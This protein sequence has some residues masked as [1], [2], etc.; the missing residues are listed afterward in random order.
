M[1]GHHALQ[2]LSFIF[3]AVVDSTVKDQ[4]VIVAMNA[5]RVVQYCGACTLPFE[6]SAFFLHHQQ[7]HV[8]ADHSHA[9]TRHKIVLRL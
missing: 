6:V 9:F 5:R 2:G 1:L 7:T 4:S 8:H 3:D